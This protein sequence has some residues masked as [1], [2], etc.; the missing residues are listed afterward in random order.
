MANP[1]ATVASA[2]MLLRW[3]LGESEAAD[4]VDAAVD[5]AIDVGPRTPDLGGADGTDAVTAFLLDRIGAAE[6]VPA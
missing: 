6:G 4:A 1:L 3:S 2:A 5:A